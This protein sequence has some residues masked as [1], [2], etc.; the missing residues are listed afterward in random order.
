MATAVRLYVISEILAVPMQ[1]EKHAFITIP[2]GAIIETS[3]DFVEPGLRPV[4]FDGRDLLAFTRDIREHTE[5][6][7]SSNGYVLA[8]RKQYPRTETLRSSKN[9]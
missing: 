3:E 7:E 9:I 2:A 6:V 5:R 1:T 4:K 8:R